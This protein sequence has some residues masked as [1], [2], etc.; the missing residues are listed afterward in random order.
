[1]VVGEIRNDRPY[2]DLHVELAF[3]PAA[4]GFAGRDF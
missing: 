2:R 1:M 3:L 4:G